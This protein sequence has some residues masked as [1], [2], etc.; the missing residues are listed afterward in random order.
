MRCGDV[1]VVDLQARGI[2]L[3]FCIGDRQRQVKGCPPAWFALH[4]ES[5][6]VCLNSQPAESQSQAASASLLSAGDELLEQP[7]LQLR[8]DAWARV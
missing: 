2:Y 7:I 6:V 8:W 5:S 1:Q 3:P 4:P